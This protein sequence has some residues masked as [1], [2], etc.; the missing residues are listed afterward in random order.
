MSQPPPLPVRDGVNATR[1]TVPDTGWATILDYVL[2]RW[3]HVDPDGIVQ[4]F[5]DGEVRAADGQVVTPDTPLTAHD[6]VWY[7][8]SVP[9]EDPIPF[10]VTV[11]HQD[12]HLLVADKPHFLPTTPGGRFVQESALVRLRNLLGL[13]HLVPMHRLDRATAGVVMF[14][15]N[16]ETRGAYQVLFE[17]RQVWK[18]YEAVTAL[19]AA[20]RFPL[21]YR[22]RMDKVKGVLTARTVD[23]PVKVSGRSPGDPA[24]PGRKTNRPTVGANAETRIELI[25]TGVS[26]GTWAGDAV[27]HVR[28]LPR[29]GRTH[30][31]RVHL[32]ALGLGILN[33]PFYPELLDAAPDDYDRPLQLLAH[34]I[35]FTDPL[36]GQPRQFSSRLRLRERPEAPR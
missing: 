30:Q 26:A 7:Y 5:R 6:F 23:Y 19:T 16:P 25:G 31:L 11:L 18:V 22:N 13:D 29:T 32:A 36:T 15:T 14:S 27:A 24:R 35:G 1:L 21:T 8:R 3:G 2:H 4:R 28:L 20:D 12:E 9:H 34:T 17:R 33:D 10:P